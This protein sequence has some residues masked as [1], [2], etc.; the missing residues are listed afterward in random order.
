MVFFWKMRVPYS[1][2]RQ[3]APTCYLTKRNSYAWGLQNF[4]KKVKIRVGRQERCLIDFINAK[5]TRDKVSKS[6]KI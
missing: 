5:D 3:K 6:E 1:Q 2:A 4:G